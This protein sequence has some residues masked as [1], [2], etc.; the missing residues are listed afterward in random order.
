MDGGAIR[1]NNSYQDGG[2]VYVFQGARFNVL[3]NVQIE[4][5][6]RTREGADP[7]DTPNNAY[8]AGSAVINIVGDLD[9][10]ARIHITG[11]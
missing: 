6:F 9:P 2:G 3:G 10:E 4:E 1:E 5:N 7:P 11:H 8:V